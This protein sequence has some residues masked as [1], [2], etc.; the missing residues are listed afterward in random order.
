MKKINYPELRMSLST[1]LKYAKNDME[2][3]IVIG[4]V[5]DMLWE[6]QKFDLAAHIREAKLKLKKQTNMNAQLRKAGE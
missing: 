5:Q 2:R 1:L 3:I 6:K 4:I